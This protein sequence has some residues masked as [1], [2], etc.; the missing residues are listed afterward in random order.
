VAAAILYDASAPG[1]FILTALALLGLV[2][3]VGHTWMVRVIMAMRHRRWNYRYL[4]VPAYRVRT[5]TLV[6]FN[7][8]FHARWAHPRP[9][10]VVLRH[11][12]I[13]AGKRDTAN[14]R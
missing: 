14:S 3:I 7:V 13:S 12:L 10:L 2:G 11:R 6:L 5:L 8:P 1:V 4:V 9:A